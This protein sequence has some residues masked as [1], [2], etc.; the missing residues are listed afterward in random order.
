MN[1]TRTVLIVDDEENIVT[2]LKAYMENVGFKVITANRG[3]L[4]L[5]LFDKFA[6]DIILLDLMMPGMTGE[7]VCR[8]I[9]MKSRVPIIMLTAKVEE[10][11][12]LNGLGIGA[13]DYI[14]KPFSLKQVSARMDAIL[15]RTSTEAIPLSNELASDDGDLVVDSMR[16]EVR[17]RGEVVILTPLEFKI[18]MT[19]AKYPSKV[20]TREELIRL[21]MGDDFEG[22]DRA[23]DSHIKNI[24]LKIEEDS[25]NPKYIITVHGVGYKFGQ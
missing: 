16:H 7:E 15:R 6:P 2:A 13:D 20:F 14:N 25:K 12:I 17:K 4:G 22:Y 9:R 19:M 3:E 5:E 1:K 8:A 11:S 24:R 18:L 10:N 23:I 21:V